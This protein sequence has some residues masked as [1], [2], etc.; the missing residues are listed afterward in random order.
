[1]RL[2]TENP[3]WGYRRIHGELAGLGYQIG[4]STV[5][6]IL[7]NA[8]IDPSTRRAG[9][10]WT[11][12]LRTQAHTIFACDVFHLDTITLHRLYAFFVIEHATRRV[13]ILGVTA[14]PT[15]AWLAQLARNLCMD[16]DDAGRRFRF[17]I[18]DRDAKF[19]AAFDAVFTAV[20][21]RI[22]RTPVRAPRANA[23]AE[24]FVGSVRRELLDRILIINL[25]DAVAALRAYEHHYNSHR[26]HRALGQAAPLRL[27]PQP[28]TNGTNSV[29]R[30]NRLGGL[31]HEYQ[32]VA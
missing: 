16:L 14:R 6:K 29:R 24:R 4:A 2:A 31:L 15:G 30:R 10:S 32:Q 28:T 21:V 1:V 23:I 8:G 18:R 20:D 12:F 25:R 7:N 22:I 26:P 19:T 3:T 11:D 27:L 9:P 17:L 5:W 13:H